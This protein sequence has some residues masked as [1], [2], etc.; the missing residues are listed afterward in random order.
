[1]KFESNYCLHLCQKRTRARGWRCQAPG[2]C[3]KEALSGSSPRQLAALEAESFA[4]KL[5]TLD[6]ES[7]AELC[8]VYNRTAPM[9]KR[10]ETNRYVSLSIYIYKTKYLYIYIYI[11]PVEIASDPSSSPEILELD[12]EMVKY[13]QKF[14]MCPKQPPIMNPNMSQSRHSS[15]PNMSQS[16]P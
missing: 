3:R 7:F 9:R 10:C 6:A 15:V 12:I 5:A 4:G 2:R 14:K 11:Y 13:N 16:D 1:M 8:S